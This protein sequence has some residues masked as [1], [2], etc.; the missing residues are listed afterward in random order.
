MFLRAMHLSTE[1]EVLSKISVSDSCSTRRN[2]VSQWERTRIKYARGG[3]TQPLL[4]VLE[5]KSTFL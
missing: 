5:T 3:E 2:L 4:Q 1:I